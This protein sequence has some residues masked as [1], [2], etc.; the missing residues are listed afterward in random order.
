MLRR[1]YVIKEFEE[2][3]DNPEMAERV[4]LTNITD[5]ELDAMNIQEFQ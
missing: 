4:Y 5:E 1:Q 2:Y 3:L